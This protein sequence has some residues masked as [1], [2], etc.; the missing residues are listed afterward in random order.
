MSGNPILWHQIK[1]GLQIMINQHLRYKLHYQCTPKVPTPIIHHATTIY[2]SM[3]TLQ[4][5]LHSARNGAAT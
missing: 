5:W 4:V 2:P 1:V 3:D